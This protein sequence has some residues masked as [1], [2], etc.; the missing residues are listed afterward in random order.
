MRRIP[1]VA[2]VIV[3]L[4]VL[5]MVRLGFWQLDRRVEK[6]ALI[7][8]YQRNI[9]EVEMS[10][11]PLA[12]KAFLFRRASI[13][14]NDAGGQRLEGAG[15]AGYRVIVSCPGMGIVQ[16]GTTLDPRPALQWQGGKVSG[17]ISQRPDHRPLIQSAFE[18]AD[19]KLMLVADPPLAGLSANSQ[20]NPDSIPNNHL[21]YAVQWFLFALTAL[22]IFGLALRKRLRGA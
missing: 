8:T 12:G 22:V 3:L 15:K 1:V 18:Q 4:A 6:E 7:A 20:P 11:M 13:T 2:T 16:L 10:T 5:L 19:E 21:A 9:N 14:C 17:W